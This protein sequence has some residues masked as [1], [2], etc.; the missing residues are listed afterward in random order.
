MS[1]LNK[2]K[3]VFEDRDRSNNNL[4]EMSN[5]VQSLKDIEVFQNVEVFKND[6]GD[7][8]YITLDCHYNEYQ[9]DDGYF[10]NIHNWKFDIDGGATKKVAFYAGMVK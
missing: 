9:L 1:K 6:T 7:V 10:E 8:E 3:I 4:R 2:H 5:F